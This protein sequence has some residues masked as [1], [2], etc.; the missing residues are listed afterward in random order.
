MTRFKILGASLASMALLACGGS[1]EKPAEGTPAAQPEAAPAAAAATPTGGEAIY[2]QRCITCH[3]ADGAGLPGTY[4]PLAGSEYATAANPGVP[5]RV[6]IHGISGPI[7]VHGAQ[8]NNL[9]P[10]Y[11][12]GVQMSDEEIAQLLTYV[13]SSFG[14]SASAVTAADVAK[15]RSETS[16]HTGPMTAELL[17]PLMK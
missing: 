17:A 7:T 12:V 16:S 13:R 4:P 8:F 15:A 11:G 5:A 6:V 10:P 9:M 3:Q 14:N 2:T 1:G